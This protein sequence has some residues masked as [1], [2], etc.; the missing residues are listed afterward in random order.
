ML[1]RTCNVC[2]E[3]I[4]IPDRG[5]QADGYETPM[6]HFESEG[7]VYNKPTVRKCKDCDLVWG[8]RRVCRPTDVSQLPRKTHGRD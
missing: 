5:E 3:T 1:K 6:S 8:I 2:E 7:H 4:Y